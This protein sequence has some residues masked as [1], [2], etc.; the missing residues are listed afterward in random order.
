V[1]NDTVDGPQAWELLLKYVKSYFL[2]SSVI[3]TA[4]QETKTHQTEL[5]PIYLQRPR[6][7]LTIVGL[8]MQTD[9]SCNLLVFD[10]AYGPSRDMR[11]DVASG[12]N[13]TSVEAKDASKFLKPYRHGKQ[14]LQCQ[15]FETLTLTGK[16]PRRVVQIARSSD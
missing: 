15:K 9:G 2:S 10:S 13:D 14:Q 1:Y 8:E 3:N 4:S 12:E 11:K 5:P 7:S 16:L 6:H